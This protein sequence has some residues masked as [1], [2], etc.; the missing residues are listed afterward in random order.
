MNKHLGHDHAYHHHFH[1]VGIDPATSSVLIQYDAND[2]L[3]G[4]DQIQPMAWTEFLEKLMDGSF[5]VHP[6]GLAPHRL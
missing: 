5:E 3:R 1:I 6:E 2:W 4:L